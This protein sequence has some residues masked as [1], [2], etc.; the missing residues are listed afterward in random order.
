MLNV[1]ALHHVVFSFVPVL[2]VPKSE[3]KN[4]SE[5]IFYC[6]LKCAVKI[7]CNGVESVLAG[8]SDNASGFICAFNCYHG[9]MFFLIG[10]YNVF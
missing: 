3:I 2:V 6:V 10:G 8:D 1:D 7:C 4:V 5:K 9:I